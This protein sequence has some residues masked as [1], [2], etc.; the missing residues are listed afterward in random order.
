MKK[1]L[2]F[3]LKYW[4]ILAAMFAIMSFTATTMHSHASDHA[5]Q[6]QTYNLKADKERELI[7]LQRR[8]DGIRREQERAPLPQDRKD[9]LAYYTGEKAYIQK[10]LRELKK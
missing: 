10:V 4:V 7:R 6:Q 9:D 5:I 2:D 3:L 1:T 8:I